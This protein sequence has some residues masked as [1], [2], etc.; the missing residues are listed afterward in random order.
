M[1]KQAAYGQVGPEQSIYAA[2]V[3]A[4]HTIGEKLMLNNGKVFYY[5]KAGAL[6]LAR[7][8]VCKGPAT[9]ALHYAATAQSAAVVGDRHVHVTV[10]ATAV[11]AN[12]YTGGHLLNKATG[13]MYQIAKHPA[14]VAS[15]SLQIDLEEPVQT[16]IAAAGVLA[17]VLSRFNGTLVAAAGDINQWLAGVPLCTVAANYYYWSQTWGL[18]G[19][20]TGT[21]DTTIYTDLRVDAAVDGATEDIALLTNQC[22]G[23]AIG[24]NGTATY[25]DAVDLKIMP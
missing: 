2:S 12:Q 18:C 5:A 22:I 21:G 11:T 9:V 13:E 1:S 8:K 25:Y 20:L 19:V 15:G 10:G 7:G 4:L 3:S 17:L 23:I 24:A 6:A 14:C 16:A